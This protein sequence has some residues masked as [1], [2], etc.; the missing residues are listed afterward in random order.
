[1]AIYA[2]KLHTWLLLACDQSFPFVY[3]KRLV[4]HKRTTFS[5]GE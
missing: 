4:D 5:E 1:M 2:H 3:P